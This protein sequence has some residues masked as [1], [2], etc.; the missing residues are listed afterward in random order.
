[1]VVRVQLKGLY[2]KPRIGADGVRI[3]RY[4]AWRGG[5]AIKG[6]DGR[7]LETGTPEFLAAF[8]AA[9]EAKKTPSAAPKTLGTLIL[10]YRS[11][12]EYTALSDHSQRN[13]AA[14][15]KKI[16]AAFGDLPIDALEDR[17][18]RGDF[19]NW[20]DSMSATPR[21][22]DYAWM[23]LA[24][25]LSVAKDR[26]RISTNPCE[27]G[28][29]LYRSH[30]IDC[31]WSEADLSRLFAEASAEVRHAVLLALWTGQRQGDLLRLPWR[32]S[33]GTHVRLRQGKG[34]RHVTV[35]IGPTLFGILSAIPRHGPVIL[36]SS[37]GKPWTS[38][39]FRTSFGRACERAGVAGLTFHDLRGTAVTRLALS[40]CP[41]QEIATITGHSLRDV[42]TILDRH[43]L[44]RDVKLAEAAIMRLEENF[45]RTN[46]V[47]R[48]VPRPTRSSDGNA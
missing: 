38:D 22:A 19:K 13:Y 8:I 24:R 11:G 4:Y 10:D 48:F 37:S 21:A 31:I 7:W 14:A 45:G 34:G 35:P 40:G 42:D 23:V 6:G 20:R 30:R 2:H 27:R 47:P 16:E 43:Y 15:M 41:P 17:G 26:G 5:P 36:A 3:D 25:I 33:D 46:S 39:G 1:M 9:H 44:S 18:V 32:S 29:R 12:V 28:G